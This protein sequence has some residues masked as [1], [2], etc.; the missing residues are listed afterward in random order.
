[1]PPAAR[2]LD[3]HLCPMVTQV[4]LASIPHVGGP[5]LGPGEPTVTIGG[6]PASVMGDSAMCSGMPPM[7]DSITQ[8]STTVM[9]GGKPAV[10][11]G[12]P[13]AHGGSVLTGWPTVMI[14]G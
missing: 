1:M 2:I 9:I 12:D 7:L 3:Q 10:R 8:G 5:I 14:G 13:T 11:M 6:L 4:A